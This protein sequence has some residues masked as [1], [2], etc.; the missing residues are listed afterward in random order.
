MV[1]DVSFALWVEILNG[2]DK[3]VSSGR[4]V[5]DGRWVSFATVDS[6]WISD[7]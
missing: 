3:T 2:R 7:S 4:V 5:D 6:G 1:R